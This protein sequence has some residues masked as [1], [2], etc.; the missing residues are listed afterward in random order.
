MEIYCVGFTGRHGKRPSFIGYVRIFIG[1]FH[2]DEIFAVVRI[3]KSE[4]VTGSDH[5]SRIGFAILDAETDSFVG[6]RT[7]TYIPEDRKFFKDI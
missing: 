4:R 6:D 5:K 7:Y 2:R 1:H 3:G